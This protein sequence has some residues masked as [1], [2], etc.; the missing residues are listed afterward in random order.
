[1]NGFIMHVG[2]RNC[3]DIDFT[4]KR[5]R[6]FAEL[7]SQL[8]DGPERE[9]FANDRHLHAA[10]PDG[11][12]HCWGV[13]SRARPSFLETSV[14]DAVFFAPFIGVHGGC[15]GY[16]GVI[17]AICELECWHASRLLWPQ[18][19]D[20]RPF[21]WVFFFDTEVGQLGWYDFLDDLHIA[22]QWNPKGWY[23]KIQPWRFRDFGGVN[24]Y[25]EHLRKDCGF[26]T[27]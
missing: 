11:T 6:T 25:V 24:G 16:I 9:F 15:I 27:L 26:R 1:M 14:G 18:T 10:F 20:D 4:M 22:H 23:R 19:P 7:V 2:H 5:R 13:P 21:P 8:P 12:F 3:I 17:K